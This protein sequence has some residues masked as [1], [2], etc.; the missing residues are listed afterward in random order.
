[1]ASS[2]LIDPIPVGDRLRESVLEFVL[3]V[4]II[5]ILLS[6]A[7][8]DGQVFMN[9]ARMLEAASLMLTERTDAVVEMASGGRFPNPE[10]V[11]WAEPKPKGRYFS[12]QRWE[13]GELVFSPSNQLLRRLGEPGRA[14]LDAG[15]SMTI[16]FRPAVAPR[17]GAVVW[18]CGDREPPAGFEASAARHSSMPAVYL[19]YPCRA[20]A[21]P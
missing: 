17:S 16:A 15:D 6:L 13:D 1:M 11:E 20:P 4:G 12:S 19:P 21:N 7:M 18:L 9:K 10:Q 3:V 14:A 8:A 5:G 2:R